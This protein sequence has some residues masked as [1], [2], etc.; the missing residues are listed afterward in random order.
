MNKK[1]TIDFI[2]KEVAKGKRIFGYGASTK[3]NT[4]LQYYGLNSKLI[5]AI[6]DKDSTKW[7]KYTVGSNIKIVSED[8]ARKEADYFFILPYAWLDT[9]VKRE[10]KWKKKGGKFIVSIPNFKVI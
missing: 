7:G 5:I 4:I 1:R 8:Q 9:F 10:A 6:A 2:K 3:G